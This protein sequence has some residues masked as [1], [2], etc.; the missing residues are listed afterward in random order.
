MSIADGTRRLL[1][2]RSGDRCA[3]C[4]CLVTEDG[5]GSAPAIVIGLEYH[6]VRAKMGGPRFRPLEPAEV[7]SSDN[8]I[9]LCP[10]DLAIVEKQPDQYPEDVLRNLKAK[11]EEWVRLLPGP[12][13]LSVRIER[14]PGVTILHLI[15]SGR[16]LMAFAGGAHCFQFMTPEFAETAEA[17]TVGGFVELVQDWAEI[18]REVAISDRL[19]TDVDLTRRLEGLRAH[20]FIAYGTR[21]TDELT[22]GLYGLAAWE[23]CVLGIFRADDPRVLAKK[24]RQRSV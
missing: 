1:W 10:S 24:A 12:A 23:T 17:E 4:K 19:R 5:V 7:D 2:A 14:D 22:G 11:H 8:L 6:I 21:R 18:W 9:L 3:K 15:Q 13:H 16:D 20:G